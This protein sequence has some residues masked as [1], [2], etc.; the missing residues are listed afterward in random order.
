MQAFSLHFYLFLR[1]I[2]LE[3]LKIYKSFYKCFICMYNMG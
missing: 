1:E 2:A 3:T